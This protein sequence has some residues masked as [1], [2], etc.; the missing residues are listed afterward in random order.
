MSNDRGTHKIEPHMKKVTKML[1]STWLLFF[2]S[3]F[4]YP[5][6][7]LLVYADNFLKNKKKITDKKLLLTSVLLKTN[8]LEK[9]NDKKLYGKKKWQKTLIYKCIAENTGK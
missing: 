4:F 8:F 2:L 9:K 5:K 6:S 3:S 7:Y 1:G